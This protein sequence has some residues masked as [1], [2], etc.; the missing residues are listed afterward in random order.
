MTFD[1][2]SYPIWDINFPNS[3]LSIV[4]VQVVILPSHTFGVHE[5]T[6]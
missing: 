1:P 2:Y 5:P 6:K 4:E 3:I